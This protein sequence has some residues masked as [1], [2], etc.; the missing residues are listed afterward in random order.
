MRGDVTVVD[1]KLASPGLPAGLDLLRPVH[2]FDLGQ[3][4][5]SGQV[6]HWERARVSGIDG[7]AGCIGESPPRFVAQD[8]DGA[9]LVPA[10][11]AEEVF[12]YLGLDHDMPAIQATFPGDDAFLAEAIAFCPGIRLIRQPLWEC[13]ATFITSSLKQVA[14][15][16]AISLEIR[17]RWG[18]PREACGMTAYSYPAPEVL[19]EAGEEALRTCALGYRAKSLHRA[20]A[21]I[22][23]G[24][25]DLQQVASC[26]DVDVA[27]AELMRLHGVGEKI[28]NC[29]L[30]FGC[31]R[32]E[33]FPIDV[34]IERVLRRGYRKRLRG[35]RLQGWAEDYFGPHAGYA[36][37]YLFHFARKTF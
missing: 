23:G 18:V 37:Q 3:T 28:A 24:E 7:F 29:V 30:L 12:R 16:R 17:R 21:A 19:A 9:L 2:P 34:W 26:D 25:I 4:L 27:R 11:D 33:T 15:I 36:Q 13:L 10:P 31:G 8:E 32:W 14:H 22:A 1:E 5:D 6:F 20:A 35:A